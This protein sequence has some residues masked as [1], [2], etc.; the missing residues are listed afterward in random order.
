[1]HTYCQKE[2]IMS[3]LTYLAL[4]LLAATAMAADRVVLFEEFTQTG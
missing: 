1:M 4:V 3:K 2:V